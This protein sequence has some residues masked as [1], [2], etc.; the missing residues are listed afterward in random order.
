MGDLNTALKL[1]VLYP[2]LPSLTS[3]SVVGGIHRVA[4]PWLLFFH[5]LKRLSQR[6]YKLLQSFSRP[7]K[8]SIRMGEYRCPSRS[9]LLWPFPLRLLSIEV[10]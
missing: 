6:A 9:L 4:G 2:P 8:A 10:Q 3:L 1:N 7:A 5:L